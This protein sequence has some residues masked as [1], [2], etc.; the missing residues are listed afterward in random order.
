MATSFSAWSRFAQVM[1]EQAKEGAGRKRK[2]VRLDR[3]SDIKAAA[4]GYGASVI[5]SIASKDH[6]TISVLP[7][8]SSRTSVPC[9]RQYRIISS[10]RGREESETVGSLRAIV[11]LMEVE[12][13]TT[14]T[15]ISNNYNPSSLLNNPS[16]LLTP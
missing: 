14:N 9:A 5:Y 1:S 4:D 11:A 8:Q 3:V 15:W 2:S 16:F 12:V 7:D 10:R 13:N 6:P